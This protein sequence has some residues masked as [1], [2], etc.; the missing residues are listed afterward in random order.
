MDLHAVPLP[1]G[2]LHDD[3]V[4]E[5]TQLLLMKTLNLNLAMFPIQTLHKMH[6]GVSDELRIQEQHALLVINEQ[7]IFKEKAQTLKEKEEVTVRS[8]QLEAA[9]VQAYNELLEL[10]ILGEAASAENIQQLAAAVKE[11]MDEIGRVRFE[12]QLQISKL[13][14]KL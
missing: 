13:Q 11:S 1:K 4:E 6:Q 7:Q 5:Q 9:I 8:Q 10:K 2:S 3:L 14:L 12:L